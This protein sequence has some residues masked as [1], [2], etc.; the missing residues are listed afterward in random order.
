MTNREKNAGNPAISS[1]PRPFSQKTRE[2]F[3]TRIIHV[4]RNRRV[5]LSGASLI[6]VY[7][8]GSFETK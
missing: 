5:R 7:Q 8:H 3:E 4:T 1:I 6:K 2:S